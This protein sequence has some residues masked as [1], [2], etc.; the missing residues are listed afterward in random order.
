M[1]AGDSSTHSTLLMRRVKEFPSKHIDSV[2]VFSLTT[3][4]AT[5]V[6]WHAVRDYLGE[7]VP[8]ETLTHSPS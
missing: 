3:Q 4:H 8:E 1:A 7:P 2:L 5:T 6:L